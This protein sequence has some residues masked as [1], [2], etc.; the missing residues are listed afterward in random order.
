MCIG[1]FMCVHMCVWLCVCGGQE[2]A[3]H[4]GQQVS[5]NQKIQ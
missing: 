5:W 1:R 2:L 3:D 4:E